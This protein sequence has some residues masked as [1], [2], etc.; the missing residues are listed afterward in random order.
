MLN[1]IE[2]KRVNIDKHSGRQRWHV[3]PEGAK[4]ILDFH[5]GDTSKIRAYRAHKNGGFG[6]ST[7]CGY[8]ILDADLLGGT[9]DGNAER[10]FSNETNHIIIGK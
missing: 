9:G 7:G 3:K 10:R 6:F 5:N 1:R 4:I 8:A 2:I